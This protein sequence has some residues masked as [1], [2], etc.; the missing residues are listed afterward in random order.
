MFLPLNFLLG[1]SRLLGGWNV[2]FVTWLWGNGGKAKRDSQSS[3]GGAGAG[4]DIGL[5]VGG[6]GPPGLLFV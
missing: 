1:Y 6:G 3:L 2:M 5:L 4:L